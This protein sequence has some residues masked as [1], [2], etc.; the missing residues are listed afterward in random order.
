MQA[1]L[2][3]LKKLRAGAST[4]PATTTVAAVPM[5]ISALIQIA[6]MFDADQATT[7]DWNSVITTLVVALGF[8]LAQDTPR[9][10]ETPIV[11]ITPTKT[12]TTKK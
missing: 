10:P 2:N 11:P 3:L 9:S 7:T 4:S 6:Y 5:Y 1:I 8:T 12:K